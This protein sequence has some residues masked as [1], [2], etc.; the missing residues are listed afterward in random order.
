MA[1]IVPIT[2]TGTPL[3]GIRTLLQDLGFGSDTVSAQNSAINATY[4]R[5][6]G[7]QRWTWLQRT[8]TE[9][10]AN[11]AST[12]TFSTID[13]STV[14]KLDS[15]HLATSPDGN[16]LNYVEF[17][18][19]RR[20]QLLDPTSTGP[21]DWSFA[22]G[23]LYFYPKADMAYSVV[24]DYQ[25]SPP[26]LVADSDI[27]L[28]PPQYVDILSWG[29]AAALAY[30]ERDWTQHAAAMAQYQGRLAEMISETGVRTK[31]S[32]NQV[33]ESGFFDPYDMP[34]F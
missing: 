17:N 30:R 8:A 11:G 14:G 12:L 18:E 16:D 34:G 21:R 5:V 28:I 10:L 31:Q 20:R 26:A 1:I 29:A 7:M 9:T 4:R 33:G 32:H 24:I 23:Q 3:S 19:L 22:N 13:A 25:Y 27:A 2:G 6:I 15:V